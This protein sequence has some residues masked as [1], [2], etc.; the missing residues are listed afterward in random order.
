MVFAR[1]STV[2]CKAI[3]LVKLMMF[4]GCALKL[5]SLVVHMAIESNNLAG[6]PEHASRVAAMK[7]RLAE[8][9]KDGPPPAYKFL[10]GAA[11]KAATAAACANMHSSGCQEPSDWINPHADIER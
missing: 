1:Q 7:A 8:A 10:P 11:Q 6:L 2:T 3:D 4:T 9:G 5:R